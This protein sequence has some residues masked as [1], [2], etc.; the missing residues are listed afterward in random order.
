M[1]K[2]VSY[3]NSHAM[4]FFATNDMESTVRFYRDLL[5]FKLYL[6][7]G[8]PEGY[9][10]LYSFEISDELSIAFF[11]W[12]TVEKNVFKQPGQPVKGPYGFDH[13]MIG[14]ETED[15]LFFL[16]DKFLMAGIEVSEVIDHGFIYAM[17]VHDPNNISLEFSYTVYN[18]RG[19][20]MFNDMSPVPAAKDGA[21]PQKGYW[22]DTIDPTPVGQRKVLAGAGWNH[23]PAEMKNAETKVILPEDF[24]E[25]E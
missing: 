1:E 8:D 3:R 23:V 13:L 24:E 19:M 11:Q 17:Y 5:G 7:N 25:Q 12:P 6:T 2:K 14:V 10:K 22:A 15:D 18:P 16:R 20:P 4:P 9:F 21:F